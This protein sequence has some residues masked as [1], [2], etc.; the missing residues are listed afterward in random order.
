M[1]FAHSLL[2]ALT[3]SANSYKT[4]AAGVE[5][6]SICTSHP[7]LETYLSTIVTQQVMASQTSI[8]YNLKK[9]KI[10]FFPSR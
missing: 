2:I 6:K 5:K 4:E 3:T 1:Q 8:Q 10:L 7:K 9:K